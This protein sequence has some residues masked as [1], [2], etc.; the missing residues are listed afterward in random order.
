MKLQEE[1]KE[2][3]GREQAGQ[4]GRNT[5]YFQ[6]YSIIIANLTFKFLIT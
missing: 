6:H 1:D 2:K 4:D 5:F 3:G